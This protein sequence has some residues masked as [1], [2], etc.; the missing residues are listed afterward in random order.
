MINVVLQDALLI[1]I[2]LYLLGLVLML[3]ISF[4]Y[5]KRIGGIGFF[6][7][8]FFLSILGMLGIYFR[9]DLNSW[10]R[11]ILANLVLMIASLF[12]LS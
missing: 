5:K 10:A 1:Y 3:F 2:L 9:L 12:L 8:Y 11:I 7:Y 4:K 6:N